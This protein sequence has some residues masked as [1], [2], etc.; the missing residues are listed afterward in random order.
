[1]LTIWKYDLKPNNPQIIKA[2]CDLEFLSVQVQKDEPKIWAKVGDTKPIVT[3]EVYTFGTGHNIDQVEK[4]S[5]NFL[6]TFQIEEGSY[7]FHAFWR[8]LDVSP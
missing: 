6:G 5:L 7:V 8:K 1:M 3:Y 4:L 2:P